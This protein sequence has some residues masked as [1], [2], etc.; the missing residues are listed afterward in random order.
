MAID[1][2]DTAAEYQAALNDQA[3]K[4]QRAGQRYDQPSRTECLDCGFAIPKKRQALG[5]V[6]RC[7]ECEGYYEN[8]QQQRGYRK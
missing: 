1:P 7:T 5:G 4:E 3:L 2:L 6:K 8:E